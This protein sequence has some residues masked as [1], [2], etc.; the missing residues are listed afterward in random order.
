M[1]QFQPGMEKDYV[2]M[3][4]MPA[5]KTLI[6]PSLRYNVHIPLKRPD[7]PQDLLSIANHVD[8]DKLDISSRNY[9]SFVFE[10]EKAILEEISNSSN[11]LVPSLELIK[12]SMEEIFNFPRNIKADSGARDVVG[13]YIYEKFGRSGL[14]ITIHDFHHEIPIKAFAQ[15]KG[16][17]DVEVKMKHFT[18][19][20]NPKR[21]F[22][23]RLLRSSVE[24]T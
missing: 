8:F 11:F 21:S 19:P 16:S 14:V 2:E 18:I 5:E 4:F 9:T 17:T 1:A 12:T 20:E 24:A 15:L 23:F 22:H 13:S 6:P 7:L 3:F 10:K